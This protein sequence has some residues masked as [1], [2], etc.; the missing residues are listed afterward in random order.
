MYVLDEPSGGLHESELPL[1]LT[2]L[3]RLQQAGNTVIV[4]EH[5]PALIAAADYVVD[6]GPRAGRYGGEVVFAGSPTELIQC[7]ASQTGRWLKSHGVRLCPL[8]K[9]I[10]DAMAT[11]ETAFKNTTLA[12]ILAEP[13]A[14][15]PLCDFPAAPRVPLPT[16]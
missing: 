10:D 5:H 8:H 11:V 13:T 6:L 9:R 7:D 12:E 3:R 1:V 2:A 4:V 15:K 14:S 16:A